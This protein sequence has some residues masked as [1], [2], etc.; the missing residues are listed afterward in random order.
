MKEQRVSKWEGQRGSQIN[1][2]FYFR[3]HIEEQICKGHYTANNCG[4]RDYQSD[5]KA[6]KWVLMLLYNTV[7]AW[8]SDFAH[9]LA[10]DNVNETTVQGWIENEMSEMTPSQE[11]SWKEKIEVYMYS[12]L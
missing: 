1:S 4:W 7:I 8:F 5:V 6:T 9:V 3:I 2:S 11:G 12:I 10:T